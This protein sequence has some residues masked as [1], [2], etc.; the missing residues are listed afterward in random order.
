MIHHWYTSVMALPDHMVKS[1][2]ACLSPA[3]GNSF[4]D[5]YC[6]SG[7]SLVEAQHYGLN[8]YGIDANPSSVLASRVKTNWWIDLHRLHTM[9]DKLSNDASTVDANHDD[10]ILRYLQ[11]SGMFDRGWIVPSTASQAVAVKRWIDSNI[12]DSE[13]HD[14]FSLALLASVVNDL[15]SVKFGPELYCVPS[16]GEHSNAVDAVLRRLRRMATDLKGVSTPAS[17]TQVRLGDARDTRSVQTAV[18]WECNP[19]YIVTSPPY[20]TDHDYTRNARLELVFMEQVV[21][22]ASL[23]RIKETMLRSHS[24]R[25]YVGGKDADAVARF[26]PVQRIK[27]EIDSRIGENHSGFEGQYSK[28]ITNYF[29]DLLRHFRALEKYLPRG[30]RLAYVVG[31]ETSYKAVYVPTGELLVEMIESYVPRLKVESL[32]VWRSRRA[33]KNACVLRE[34]VVFL[35][36]V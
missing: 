32:M 36:A 9:I 35:S 16:V 19:V 24:K 13:I 7:T 31:D 14:L 5:P 11:K 4:F 28:V 21:D 22:R 30:S 10:P 15:S 33:R 23:R 1:L 18:E 29:G 20:P 17:I 3:K 34:S 2:L 26:G 25:I 6:G 8:A 27:C 12:A